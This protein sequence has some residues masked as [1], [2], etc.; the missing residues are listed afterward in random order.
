MSEALVRRFLLASCPEN[1]VVLDPF[2]GAGTTALVA[3]QLGR[4]AISIEINPAY[5]KGVR[6]RVAAELGNLD[7]GSRTVAAE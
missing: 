7:E 1:S 6:Q 2:G 5:T 3:L 4:R